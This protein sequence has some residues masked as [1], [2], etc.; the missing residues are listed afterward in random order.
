MFRTTLKLT[1]EDRKAIAKKIGSYGILDTYGFHK[2]VYS[3]FPESLNAEFSYNAENEKPNGDIAV[4]V[5]SDVEPSLEGLEDFDITVKQAKEDSN[6]EGQ[7]RVFKLLVNN[8]KKKNGYYS[9]VSIEE[10]PEWLQEKAQKNGFFVDLSSLK[11][12]KRFVKNFKDKAQQERKIYAT[13]CI[14]VLTVTDSE[15]FSKVLVNGIGRSKAYGFGM[16]FA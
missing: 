4:V 5:Q 16:L 6:A 9:P 13:D 11:I 8:S 3:L 14:G 7:E 2:L 12:T 15:A 10:F 1:L